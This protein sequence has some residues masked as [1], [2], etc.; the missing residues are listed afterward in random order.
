MW[1]KKICLT[2]YKAK[3]KRILTKT[4]INMKTIKIY[5]TTCLLI[6]AFSHVVAQNE[7]YNHQAKKNTTSELTPNT[8][9]KDVPIE[10]YY[11]EADYKLKLQQE[12]K[13]NA[14]NEANNTDEYA[15]EEDGDKKKKDKKCCR[16]SVAAEVALEIAVDVFINVAAIV[17]HF[18]N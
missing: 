17:V 10:N 1:I 9:V 16:G 11:T 8:T 2:L 5:F 14:N 3:I 7:I 6:F 18:W 13:M 4:S 15:V 12:S